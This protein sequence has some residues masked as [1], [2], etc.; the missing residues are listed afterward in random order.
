MVKA[1]RYNK[2][3]FSFSLV[4]LSLFLIAC[5]PL[6]QTRRWFDMATGSAEVESVSPANNASNVPL[7]SKIEITFKEEMD[8]TTLNAKGVVISYENKELVVFLNPF[9]NSQYSY[10]ESSKKLTITPSQNFVKNQ[11]VNVVLTDSIRSSN[12]KQLPYGSSNNPTERYIFTFTTASNGDE[13]RQNTTQVDQSSSD[14]QTVIDEETAKSIAR[15]FIQEKSQTYIY[16]GKPETLYIKSIAPV[17][18]ESCYDI[19]IVFVSENRGY[20]DRSNQGISS[21]DAAHEVLVSIRNGEVTKAF[22]DERWDVMSQEF[23]TR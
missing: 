3:T 21:E 9:L 11:K 22:M 16:D 6:N 12:G 23:I 13:G 8:P 2:I 20:G 14:N 10:D 18:C 19:S 7:D 5:N 15:T 1:K 17:G 4:F